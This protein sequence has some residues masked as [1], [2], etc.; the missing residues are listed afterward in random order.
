MNNAYLTVRRLPYEEPHHTQLEITASNGVFTGSTD[1][2]CNVSDLSE[3]GK[4]LKAFPKTVPDEYKYEYGSSDPAA[5]F[6]R[7]F[8][9]RVY[10]VGSWGKCAL[11]ISI[12]Q[13]PS[14]PEENQGEQEGGVCLFSIPAEPASINRLG[15]LFIT[16]GKLQHLEFKWVPDSDTNDLYEKHQY[17]NMP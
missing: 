12:N 13:N 1:I 15:D 8:V 16:F 7:H 4:K 10:T 9:F 17:K 14:E 6:Y 2:Y 5:R 11:Q 3:I